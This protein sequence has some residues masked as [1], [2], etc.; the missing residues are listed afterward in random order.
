MFFTI[1][2]QLLEQA[3]R[4]DIDVSAAA[5]QGVRSAIRAAQVRSDR[6]AYRRMPEQP[7]PFWDEAEAWSEE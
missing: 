1:D 3:R 2:K 7:D 4:L 5:R 6:E